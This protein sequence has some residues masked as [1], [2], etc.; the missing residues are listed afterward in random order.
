[1]WRPA[2]CRR[3]WLMPDRRGEWRGLRAWSQPYWSCSGSSRAPS[4]SVRGACTS[5]RWPWLALAPGGASRALLLVWLA[6]VWLTYATP[7]ADR[8]YPHYSDRHV[9]G[10]LRSAG[11]RPLGSRRC[12]AARPTPSHDRSHR[13]PRGGLGGVHGVHAL[14]PSVS[15]RP[16]AAQPATTVS[17]I[18]TRLRSPESC[19]HAGSGSDDPVI[20]F[21]VT[22][23]LDA[24]P[25][26]APIV[27]VR[28]GFHDAR[29]LQCTGTDELRLF[30][31]LSMC[32]PA[33]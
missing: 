24:S 31:V 22:G 16:S 32:L 18:G 25:G 29:P 13:R 23:D 10:D 27:S 21:L 3:S 4:A 12:G 28:D 1:M 19:K 14:L 11:A 7:A 17:C 20:D 15:R 26:A 5:R 33:P 6:G 2:A 8:V 9:S 30:G